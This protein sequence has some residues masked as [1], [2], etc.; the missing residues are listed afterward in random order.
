MSPDGCTSPSGSTALLF[1]LLWGGRYRL[2]FW[3]AGDGAQHYGNTVLS[4][5]FWH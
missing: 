5:G 3:L 2:R 4:L 1:L